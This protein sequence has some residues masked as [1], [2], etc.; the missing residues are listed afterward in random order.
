MSEVG[1]ENRKKA[2]G[3]EHVFPASQPP[4]SKMRTYTQS[5]TLRWLPAIAWMA[6]IFWLSAQPNLPEPPSAWLNLV[7]R[8]GAHFTAYAV[9]ALCYLYAL[10]DNRP[11]HRRLALLLAILYALSDEYHQ[12]WTPNRHPA[13]SDVFIDTAGALTAVWL[14]SR[15]KGQA[16][17]GKA[18]SWAAGS[19]QAN[20]EKRA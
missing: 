8:K 5:T 20:G 2:G 7:L 9:L 4:L 17:V 6:L 18:R 3:R 12:A 10:G 19:G 16:I 1:V 11:W 15:L 14:W 13:L